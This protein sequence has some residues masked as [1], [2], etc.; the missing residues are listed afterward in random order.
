[1]DFR[2]ESLA[3]CGFRSRAL[4]S[5]ARGTGGRC[6]DLGMASVGLGSMWSELFLGRQTSY[7]PIFQNGK[8]DERSNRRRGGDKTHKVP[9][10]GC[11]G[12]KTLME[13]KNEIG[14]CFGKINFNHYLF[15]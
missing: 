8:T 14:T 4:L 13:R 11:E 6:T 1:M 3:P 2:K 7:F 10:A 15:T 5:K 9:F 12:S